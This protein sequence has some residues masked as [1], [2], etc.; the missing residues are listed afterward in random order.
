MAG[1]GQNLHEGEG[2]M[3][4]KDGLQMLEEISF[5]PSC[6]SFKTRVSH[7]DLSQLQKLND[8]KLV[9]EQ[10]LSLITLAYHCL[11]ASL[12]TANLVF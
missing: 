10:T 9:L 2:R 5:T 12:T 4:G 1:T 11:L 3:R 6:L 8:S 7:R